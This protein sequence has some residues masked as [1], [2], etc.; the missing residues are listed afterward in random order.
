MTLTF[1]PSGAKRDGGSDLLRR[2]HLVV[3]HLI[4]LR[5]RGTGRNDLVGRVEVGAVVEPSEELL[6]HRRLPDEHVDE[7][8]PADIGAIV[9]AR[10]LHELPDRV[11][12]VR[13][14]DVLVGRDEVE[15]DEAGHDEADQRQ[16]PSGGDDAKDPWTGA[17]MGACSRF[18]RFTVDGR[19]VCQ[20]FP[21]ELLRLAD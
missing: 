9:S 19:H 17:R 8:D 14:E 13:K 11:R 4:L 1:L 18:H 7:V 12:L 21:K 5:G 3:V 20:P 10:D 2:S 16:H 6:E 15:R